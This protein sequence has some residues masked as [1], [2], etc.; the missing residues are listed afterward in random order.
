MQMKILG[1]ICKTFAQKQYRHVDSDWSLEM[2]I[3]ANAFFFSRLPANAE[4]G[5]CSPEN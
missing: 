4:L 2:P 1:I 5:R 3:P